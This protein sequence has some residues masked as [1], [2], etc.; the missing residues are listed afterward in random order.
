MATEAEI[1]GV[2][3]TYLIELYRMGFK[4]LVPMS[5]YGNPIGV[6]VEKNGVPVIE[7]G[8]QKVGWTPIYE[9]PHYWTEETLA[10]QSTDFKD[11]VGV[12]LVDIGLN[13]EQ[14]ILYD[15]ILDIDSDAV[16]DKLFVLMNPR[17][18][19]SLIKK[20]F[21]QGCVVKSRKPKGR[22]IHW[23]SHKQYKP[24]TSL[25]C[26]TGFEFEIKTG[27]WCAPL[28]PTVHR[29]DTSFHYTWEV[30]SESRIPVSDEFYDVLLEVLQDYLKPKSDKNLN[31]Y[32][33]DDLGGQKQDF[34]DESKHDSGNGNGKSDGLQL[35][36][37]DVENIRTLIQPIYKQ[38]YRNSIAFSLSC[39]FRR[40]GFSK[41]SVIAI[42]EKLARNDGISDE[43]DIRRAISVVEDVF[44]EDITIIAGNEHLKHVIYSI[45]GSRDKANEIFIEIFKIIH[46]VQDRRPTDEQQSPEDWLACN[47]MAEYV[48]MTTTDNR[49]LF[50]YDERKGVYLRNQEWRIRQ[51]CRSIDHD[52]KTYTIDE[53]INR[54]KDR[55]YVDRSKFDS[56]NDIINVKN[57]LLNIHTLELTKHSPTHL[58]TIQL[59]V[60]YDRKATCPKILKFFSE[61]LKSEDIRVILQLIG[62]CLYKTNRYERAFIFFGQGS[63][64]KST[65]I[66]LIEY[67]LG[68]TSLYRN[69]SH[70][71]LHDL[72][73]HKFKQAELYG[74]LANVFADLGNKKISSD[75]W[76]TI[77][78]LISGDSMTVERKNR[79]PFEFTTHAKLIFSC[80]EIPE[81]PDNTYATWRRLILEFEN[82][83]EENKDTN[84]IDKLISEQEMSGLLNMALIALKRLI[85]NNTFDY[86]KDI[87]AVRKAYDLNSNTMAKF[88]QERLVV[89]KH[90]LDQNRPLPDPSDKYFEICR[91]VY[92]DYIDFCNPE[93]RK[94][95]TDRELGIYLKMTLAGDWGGRRRKRIDHEEEY[96]YD[97]IRLKPK[98]KRGDSEPSDSKLNSEN[99]SSQGDNDKR[100][101]NNTL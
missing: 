62:Y 83:F 58:S 71:S 91:D 10:K 41:D 8:K 40:Q 88:K 74:K 73:Q 69:V 95:K 61:V 98:P 52:V 12:C 60:R 72:A 38:G 86:T 55:T 14:G 68:F 82:V 42:V 23:L 97:G 27:K 4:K 49:E 1:G 13:D 6:P 84:L 64:G 54:V 3:S 79:D 20:I 16:Y 87:E 67:F 75:H 92:G 2:T 29:N 51:L 96:I 33:K 22:H 89:V 65:L 47:V 63:N 76:G 53:V 45:I 77:K 39:V 100:S 26:K 56:N 21:E 25:D 78:M 80:N 5:R 28:P 24:I 35:K 43:S 93:G 19:C 30:R 46:D 66:H 17:P 9:N 37:E 50:I 101:L 85:K 7:D 99:S 11:G 48:C 57:G 94:P 32:A 31:D 59:P 81:L 15:N 18:K 34:T 70:V 44:K 36:D 90:E